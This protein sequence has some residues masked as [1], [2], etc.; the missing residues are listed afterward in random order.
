MRVIRAIGP[1]RS[2]RASA[3][4]LAVSMLAACQ[5]SRQ[6]IVDHENQLAAAGFVVRPAD[7]AERRDLLARLPEHKFVQRVSGDKVHYVYADPSFC[8]CLYV[9]SQAAYG[10]YQQ[11][12]QSEAQVKELESDLK[13][14]NNAAEDDDLN[15]QVYS[16][17][18]Y[19]WEAWGPWD[20]EY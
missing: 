13:R 16:D 1:G 19:H 10:R 5:T 3:V 11:N 4:F 9:G 6:R 2:M 20:Y 14:R 17:P 15:A 7:T 8:K 12:K 18:A